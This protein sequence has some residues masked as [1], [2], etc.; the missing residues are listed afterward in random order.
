[1]REDLVR[2]AAAEAAPDLDR[3]PDPRGRRASARH[4]AELRPL[5][6]ARDEEAPDAA[7]PDDREHVLRVLDAHVLQLR[8]GREAAVGGHDLDQGG[9]LLGGQGRVAQGHGAHARRLR[10]RRDRHPPPADRRAGARR[11]ATPTRTSSTP[12]TASTSTRPRRCSTSS[13]SSEELG[14]LDGLHVAIVGDVLH[15]RVARSEHPGADAHGRAVTLVG[16]PPLMPRGIEA[17]GCEVSTDIAAIGDA[18]VVYVL[19]MQRERME[20][21]ANY[22]PEPARVQR[23]LGRHAGAAPAGP[24]GHAPRPD[25]P[26]RRDRPARRGLAPSR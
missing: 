5:D 15:S 14:K 20:E 23:A 22:V 1:M 4:G 26:R 21:G 24:E 10:P 9:R 25:E 3:R 12:A 6:G 16:P 18:D 8:A 7:R 13:R 19:R 17:M 11:A 2:R